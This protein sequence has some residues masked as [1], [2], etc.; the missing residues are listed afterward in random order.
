[1]AASAPDTGVGDEDVPASCAC[2]QAARR[3]RLF[4]SRLAALRSRGRAGEGVGSSWR[5]KLACRAA[6]AGRSCGRCGSRLKMS[7]SSSRVKPCW[8]M[9]PTRSCV[10]DSHL[11][12]RGPVLVYYPG[13][14]TSQSRRR[15]VAPLQLGR[16]MICCGRARAPSAAAA[17]VAAPDRGDLA[18]FPF[19]CRA[20]VGQRDGAP[21]A[22]QGRRTSASAGL[23]I[24]GDPPRPGWS[25]GWVD[26]VDVHVRRPVRGP[27]VQGC[28]PA[29]VVGIA[30]DPPGW[31]G[32]GQ[33]AVGGG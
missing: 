12:H 25:G 16:P 5:V 32:G 28:G 20:V 33:H 26:R 4:S 14:S 22:P 7:R 24:P 13:G 2:G 1:V 11:G 31:G 8:P 15:P 21:D 27:T 17:L 6:M 10:S 30:G 29:G 9:S 3:P 18:P 19:P 23:V